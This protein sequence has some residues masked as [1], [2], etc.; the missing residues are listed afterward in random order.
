MLG[1]R[2]LALAFFVAISF[3]YWTGLAV[4]GVAN[5]VN[6]RT[7]RWLFLAE[8][9]IGGYTTPCYFVSQ[10]IERHIAQRER[11]GNPVMKTDYI[12]YY[13]ESDMAQIYLATAGLLNILAI[14]DAITRAQTGGLPTFYRDLP[15]EAAA[16]SGGGS[17]GPPRPAKTRKQEAAS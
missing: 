4:G 3:P 2:G 15:A 10:A 9:G 16:A 12:A 14:L 17:A 7:N 6:P 13:P 1:H 11:Q 5:S 8:L